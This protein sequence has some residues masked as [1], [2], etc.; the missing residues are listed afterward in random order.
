[1]KMPNAVHSQAHSEAEEQALEEI[2]EPVA[3]QRVTE[4][5]GVIYSSQ[6]S[7]RLATDGISLTIPRSHFSFV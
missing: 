5:G 2:T 6:V 7:T 3:C 4:L 1:M